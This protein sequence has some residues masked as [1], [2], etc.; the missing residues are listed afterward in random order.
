MTS[1]KGFSLIATPC[2][3]SLYSIPQYRSI[4]LSASEY[5]TDGYKEG[6]LFNNDGGLRKCKCGE[7]YLL[8][9]A[10]KLELD[11]KPDT[12]KS[13]Y[14]EGTDLSQAIENASNLELELIA[15]RLF[16]RYLNHP[17]RDLYRKHREVQ[18]AKW[19]KENPRPNKFK[20]IILGLFKNIDYKKNQKSKPFTTP[21]FDPS[22]VQVK[23][24]LKLLELITEV[25]DINNEIKD[26]DIIEIAEIYRELGEFD[27]SRCILNEYNE[28]EDSILKKIV[29]EL[30]AEKNQAP[31]RYK[32]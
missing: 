30:I 26:D 23:N 25:S 5:W 28:G 14:V 17:Y 2:C 3:R 10:I 15:R 16:W 1:V 6:S 13:V 19:E 31:V 29:N 32:Y 24:M 9:D 18:E 11:A 21:P 27:M 4:N 12:P 20:I 8:K 7:F 22:Q